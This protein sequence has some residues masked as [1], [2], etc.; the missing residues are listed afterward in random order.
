MSN[1]PNIFIA[2]RMNSLALFFKWFRNSEYS[3]KLCCM[4]QLRN[5]KTVVIEQLTICLCP[6][7]IS[8]FVLDLDADSR[9]YC[10]IYIYKSSLI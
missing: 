10:Y 5:L 4:K 7:S 1:L 8:R 6:K 3:L 2:S 9:K